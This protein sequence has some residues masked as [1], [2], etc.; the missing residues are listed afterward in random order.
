MDSEI[1]QEIWQVELNGDVSDH[2]FEEI[3][4]LIEQGSLLRIDRV[5]KGDLRWIEAGKVPSLIEIFNAIDERNPVTP[6]VTVTRLG[7]PAST[8]T[9]N[10][11]NFSPTVNIDSEIKPC[12]IHEEAEAFYVC[13]TC[14]NVFC[15][16]CPSSYGGSVKI[17]PFCGAFCRRMEE[18]KAARDQ[19]DAYSNAVA[20]GFGFSDLGASLAYPFKFKASLILGG[21]MFMAFSLGQAAVGFGGM[22]MF[23]AA[24]FCFLLANTLSFGIL[25]NTVD[26][27]SQGKIGLNFMPSFDD[28]SIWDD[29]VHPFFL[30]IGVYIV[31]FGPLIAVFLITIFMLIGS[32]KNEMNTFQEEAARTVSPQIPLASKAANQSQE[33]R[34]L[35]NKQAE[36]QRA[37]VESMEDDPFEDSST[38]EIPELPIVDQTEASVMEAN[39]L[40]GKYRAAQAESVIGKSPEKLAEERSELISQILG[41]GRFLL[42]VGGLCLLWG[43]LYFPAA[44][45]VAAY[46]RSFFA[47]LNPTVGFDTIR[48]LGTDYVK[49]LGMGLILLLI[50]GFLSSVV[51]TVLAPFDLPSMGNLPARAV[52]SLFTFYF[53]IVFACVIGFAFYKASD[54]LKLFR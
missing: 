10:P 31:S 52:N 48:R 33:V 26:N 16:A 9:S 36:A 24:L 17:C 5:K 19:A 18:A 4:T 46:T 45:A 13:D 40:I 25:A 35:L 2:R 6:V 14:S 42:V 41:Y 12:S 11:P 34:D 37:R 21:L 29:V 28:F 54:R 23:G 20:G 30:S 32:V 1:S 38:G 8:Q 51:D 39:E 15:K 27:F 22:A 53:S 43:L 47:T 7:P 44:C 50:A 3:A 49:I